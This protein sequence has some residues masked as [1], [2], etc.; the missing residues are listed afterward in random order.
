MMVQNGNQLVLI[1]QQVRVLQRLQR[2][3][4]QQVRV[5]RQH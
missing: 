3:H 5:V 1:Q 4:Q 2:V